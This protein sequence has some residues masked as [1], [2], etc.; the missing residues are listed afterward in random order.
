MNPGPA[1]KREP[2][3]T[4]SNYPP[5]NVRD[6]LSPELEKELE[7]ALGGE[8]LDAIIDDSATETATGDELAP[9]TRV[10]GTVVKFTAKISLLNWAAARRGCCHSNNS[11]KKT[12]Q[13]SAARS[14]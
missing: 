10:T 1:S 14:K 8:S 2:E 6:Q 11:R 12:R 4:K 9:D 7:A 5:P 3:P 13:K